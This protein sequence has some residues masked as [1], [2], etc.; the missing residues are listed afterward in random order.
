MNSV[1]INRNL[2]VSK[3]FFEF[4]S[5]TSNIICGLILNIETT[6]GINFISTHSPELISYIQTEKI[7]PSQN[8]FEQKGRT[9][10]KIGR[11]VTKLIPQNYLELYGVDNSKIE[12]FVNCFKSWFD[13][14]TH[15]LKIVEGE[16]LREWYLDSNYFSPNGIGI[17]TLW[18]SCMRYQKR[19]KF[20]DLYCKNPGIKMII[21]TTLVNNEEKLRAR[22]L[23][24]ENTKVISS[25]ETLPEYINIM[26]RIY[27]VFDSDVTTLK[28]WAEENNYI[29]KWEQNSKTHQYFQIKGEP[30]KIKC[31]F[32]LMNKDFGYYPYLDT[33]PFFNKI[34]GYLYNDEY[35]DNWQYKLTQADGGLMRN[36][37]NEEDDEQEMELDDMEF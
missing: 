7:N 3:E 22:A 2:S 23:L 17:G 9:K 11:L 15:S 12:N 8:P 37:N 27:S 29:P 20:L 33:L 5:N 4:L 28:K 36:R 19:Q 32:K 25:N 18:N 34:E 16:E 21:M 31:S 14:S 10:L 13:N 24:W 6:P 30:I 1:K 35:N 26:D